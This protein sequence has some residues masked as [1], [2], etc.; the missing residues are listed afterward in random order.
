MKMNE[1]AEAKHWLEEYWEGHGKL[2][3]W[4][5]IVLAFVALAGYLY[6][7]WRGKSVYQAQTVYSE[8]LKLASNEEYDQALPLVEQVIEQYDWAPTYPFAV[9]LKGDILFSQ[10]DAAS[11]VEVYGQLAG[12]KEPAVAGGALVAQGACYENLEQDREAEEVYQSVIRRLPESGFATEAHFMLA[13]LYE[14]QGEEQKAIAQY[15]E[16]PE[17]SAWWHEAQ[18]R[19]EWLEAPVMALEVVRSASASS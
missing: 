5:V 18:F 4:A 7:D 10:G 16:I 9:L 19:C 1:M 13:K 3:T 8:A 15:K 14:R 17:D 6:R 12:R 11:A 2:I